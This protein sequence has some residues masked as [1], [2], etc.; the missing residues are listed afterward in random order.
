M[1]DCFATGIIGIIIGTLALLSSLTQAGRDFD[2]AGLK[3]LPRRM[4]RPQREAFRN[5]IAIVV[6]AAFLI[7]G[8]SVL[9]YAVYSWWTGKV[10][11]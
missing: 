1:I 5:Q 9:G 6:G 8:I 2:R 11:G 7:G 3:M 4:R 10:C